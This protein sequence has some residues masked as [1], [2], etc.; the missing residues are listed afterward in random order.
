MTD[1]G[2][3]SAPAFAEMTRFELPLPTKVE[4]MVDQTPFVEYVVRGQQFGILLCDRRELGDAPRKQDLE[5]IKIRYT[6]GPEL[7]VIDFPWERL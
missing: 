4:G 7:R 6:A 5:R 3:F 1:F 2:W